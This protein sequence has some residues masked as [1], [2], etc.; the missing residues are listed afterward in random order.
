MATMSLDTTGAGH[1]H[2]TMRRKPDMDAFEITFVR[3]LVPNARNFPQ[4]EYTGRLTEG[5]RSSR[6]AA[7]W[8]DL[9]CLLPV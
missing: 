2:S 5:P 4:P 6:T 3:R 7:W 9:R 8:L 1:K